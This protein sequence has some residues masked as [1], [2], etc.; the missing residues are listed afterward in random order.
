MLRWE[1]EYGGRGLF[2]CKEFFKEEVE[3]GERGKEGQAL[4]HILNTTYRFFYGIILMVISLTILLV[5]M[6]CH[7]TVCLFESR[8][9]SVDNVVC[10]NLHV[11]LLFGFFFIP[12]IPTEILSVYTDDIFLSVF[13]DGV[14]NGQIQ[15]VKITAK[16]WWKFYYYTY[17]IIITFGFF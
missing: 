8:C 6:P 2:C 9:N 4:G 10:K 5:S 13:T 15:L 11:I 7:Y 12:S 14:S 16:Y 3:I 17:I 1:G